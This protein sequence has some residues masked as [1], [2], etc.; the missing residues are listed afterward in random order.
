MEASSTYIKYI[1]EVSVYALC[2]SN[3]PG[4][5]KIGLWVKNIYSTKTLKENFMHDE[6]WKVVQ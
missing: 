2:K 4:A 6:V 5:L 1:D 3:A